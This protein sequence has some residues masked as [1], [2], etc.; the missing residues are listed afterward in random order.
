MYQFTLPQT[1]LSA[2]GINIINPTNQENNFILAICMSLKNYQFFTHF[3]W[4]G[5]FF[6]DLWLLFAYEGY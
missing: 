1:P 3:Y 2:L 5:P 6:I 4:G